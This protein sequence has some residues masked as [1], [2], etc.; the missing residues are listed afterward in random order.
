MRTLLV[1]FISILLF[2]FS[3]CFKELILNCELI[4]KNSNKVTCV[5]FDLQVS[6]KESKVISINPQTNDTIIALHLESTSMLFLPMGIFDYF[7]YV[8][9]LRIF[10]EKQSLTQ[11]EAKNFKHISKLKKIY[12]TNQL[13]NNLGPRIF[14]EA[15]KLISLYLPA[16]NIETIHAKAFEGLNECRYLGLNHNKIKELNVDV[17]STLPMLMH[18]NLEYNKI[19]ELPKSIFSNNDDIVIC[20]LTGNNLEQIPIM[21]VKKVFEKK[22]NNDFNPIVTLDDNTCPS[23]KNIH[24]KNSDKEIMSQHTSCMNVPSC[25][26]DCFYTKQMRRSSFRSNTEKVYQSRNAFDTIEDIIDEEDKLLSIQLI[27]INDVIGKLESFL[28]DNPAEIIAEDNDP[29]LKFIYNMLQPD[30]SQDFNFI[31]RHEDEDDFKFASDNENTDDVHL[32]LKNMSFPQ[33]P[34]ETMPIQEMLQ[35]NEPFESIDDYDYIKQESENVYNLYEYFEPILP[36]DDSFEFENYEN[37]ENIQETYDADNFYKYLE[38][39]ADELDKNGEYDKLF[40]SYDYQSDLN[41][42]AD[43][44]NYQIEDNIEIIYK[45]MTSVNSENQIQEIENDFD[46]MPEDKIFYQFEIFENFSNEDEYY[47]QKIEDEEYENYNNNDIN[48]IFTNTEKNEDE[49]EIS[50]IHKNITLSKEPLNNISSQNDYEYNYMYYVPEI[51]NDLFTDIY[52]EHN[53]NE[54]L[55]DANKAS[56]QFNYQDY[57]DDNEDYNNFVQ[58]NIPSILN[59]FEYTS[60]DQNSFDRDDFISYLSESNDNEYSNSLDFDYLGNQ[61]DGLFSIENSNQITEYMELSYNEDY[62]YD[63]DIYEYYEYITDNEYPTNE[64]EFNTYKNLEEY[65]NQED[66]SETLGFE[67]T[68]N[69]NDYLYEENMPESEDNNNE[70]SDYEYYDEI[71]QYKDSNIGQPKNFNETSDEEYYSYE[72]KMPENEISAEEYFYNYEKY[73]YTN[74]ELQKLLSNKYMNLNEPLEPEYFEVRDDNEDYPSE[75]GNHHV[76]FFSNENI[77]DLSNYNEISNQIAEYMKLSY[78]EDYYYD[79]EIDE[80]Y[81]YIT[82]NEYPTNEMEFNTY[83]NLEEHINHEDLSK[84][85]GLEETL[86]QNDYFYEENISEFENNYNEYSLNQYEFENLQKNYYGQYEN[87]NQYEQSGE[88]LNSFDYSYFYDNMTD[89]E[90]SGYEYIPDTDY[91]SNAYEYYINYEDLK[92]L[93]EPEYISYYE[94]NN[95]K[96]WE[97][98]EV[99]ELMEDIVTIQKQPTFLKLQEDMAFAQKEP[100]Q[101][102]DMQ[103]DMMIEQIQPFISEMDY[104]LHVEHKNPL[105]LNI[106]EDVTDVNIEES[107]EISENI[108]EYE[109]EEIIKDYAE[110]KVETIEE[111]AENIGDIKE[112]ENS[113]NKIEEFIED[114]YDEETFEPL[115]FE[116]V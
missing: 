7:P 68:S 37:A 99:P 29:D 32:I 18:L 21:P 77:E 22:K 56:I 17:F 102:Y 107:T 9:E 97:Y 79:P 49:D 58:E 62:Y 105:T 53:Y 16:N 60:E 3:N 76:E 59:P 57:D 70:Y 116:Y 63:P 87:F 1:F 67:E 24:G 88:N 66:L 106:Q 50:F 113:F 38:L 91:S 55:I 100:L 36:I 72:E 13:I 10:T 78:N 42:Q 6:N 39:N 64:M 48:I 90:Y 93:P 69:Q 109:V 73:E 14:S 115:D 92:Q 80:Y 98:G 25:I 43:Y 2:N 47:E 26:S 15:S 82:D 28:E 104:D 27:K 101:P 75:I 33:Y 40:N 8:E 30:L 65:N 34:E 31:F 46:H 12:I 114:T 51:K 89:T 83:E 74:E 103:E 110:N 44:E 5:N 20:E 86:N 61:N 11:I 4:N 81:E 84:F 45:N 85:L 54:Y 23:L 52:D 95:Q 19:K 71:L 108:T 94:D 96:S 35:I 41:S 111:V 112:T